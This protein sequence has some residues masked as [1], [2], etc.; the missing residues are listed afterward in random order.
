MLQSGIRDSYGIPDYGGSRRPKK[1]R[2]FFYTCFCDSF[3]CNLNTKTVTL[4][5]LAIFLLVFDQ[6]LA[7]FCIAKHA[8]FSDSLEHSLY[9]KNV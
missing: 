6:L 5:L 4:P 2:K 8:A 3:I 7:F 9:Y 1:S